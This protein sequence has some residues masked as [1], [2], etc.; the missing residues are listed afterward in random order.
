[1]DFLEESDVFS[2]IGGNPDEESDDYVPDNH[3]MYGGDDGSGQ[4][5]SSDRNILS[6]ID[7]ILLYYITYLFDPANR[8]KIQTPGFEKIK[9]ILPTSLT[10]AQRNLITK[11]KFLTF[12]PSELKEKLTNLFPKELQLLDEKVKGIELIKRLMG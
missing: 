9:S 3:Y 8:E 11:N 12:K 4:N 10:E 5:M 1:M 6:D 7:T 2:M